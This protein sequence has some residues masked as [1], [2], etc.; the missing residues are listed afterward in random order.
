MP[1][2]PVL[3][4]TMSFTIKHIFCPTS[5]LKYLKPRYFNF[6]ALVSCI[7][8][9]HL[10]RKFFESPD[11]PGIHLPYG[12]VYFPRPSCERYAFSISI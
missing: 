3:S 4:P 1:S 11:P 12:R 2:L 5:V 9:A 7:S 10:T 6:Q 8:Q